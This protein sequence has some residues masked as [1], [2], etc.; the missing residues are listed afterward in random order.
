[1]KILLA[2]ILPLF[3]SFTVKGKELVKFST[4]DSIQMTADLYLTESLE[5]PFIILCHQAGWSRGEYLEIAPKLNIL[6]YNCM[7]I[8]QRSGGSVNGI[9]NET[10]KLAKLKKLGVNYAD[11]EVDILSAI[12]YVKLNYSKASKLILWGSSYSSAL[13]LKIT[14][15]RSDI[16]GV[17]A[18]SPGEYFGRFGKPNDYIQQNAKHIKVP[19]FITSKKSEKESWWTIYQSILSKNKKYFL[20]N[21]SGQ[22]GSRALWEKF[23]EHNDYWTAVKSFLKTI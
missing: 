23:E 7:A 2:I 1:M 15:E 9:I 6:G 4:A 14:G 20:P 18:F 12:N 22:H 11:A 16:D 21:K 3:I 8:D 5:N 10:H 17:L 13:V 19:A